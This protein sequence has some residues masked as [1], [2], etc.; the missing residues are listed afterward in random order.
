MATRFKFWISRFKFKEPLK[1]KIYAFNSVLQ[2]MTTK[3]FVLF[4][5]FIKIG[6]T[7]L[8]VKVIYGFIE[9]FVRC[10]TMF[11]TSIVQI[12]VQP[13]PIMHF[14]GLRFRWVKPKSNP[15]GSH[16]NRPICYTAIRPRGC[17]LSTWN[18]E[19][20]LIVFLVCGCTLFS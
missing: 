18:L 16:N 13:P 2:S 11:D 8:L 3:L 14:I 7:I 1:R 19:R 5:T 9:L 15:L 12:L 10:F 20:V 4:P 6:S 17:R